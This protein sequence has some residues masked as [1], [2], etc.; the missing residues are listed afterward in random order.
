[1]RDR[2]EI[3][4]TVWGGESFGNRFDQLGETA[5]T[6][7]WFDATNADHLK[8]IDSRLNQNILVGAAVRWLDEMGGYAHGDTLWD[9][10]LALIPRALWPDKPIEAGS[11]SV[12]SQYTGIQFA[13]GTSVGL[14]HVMEF[15]VN[16]GTVGVI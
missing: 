14:G 7:E 4:A 15:Y 16:Y 1:M 12:V 6:F 5:G 11:G 13:T 8:R 9:S 2:T 3:R 10:L